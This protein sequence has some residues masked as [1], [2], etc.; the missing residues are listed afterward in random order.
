MSNKQKNLTNKSKTQHKMSKIHGL[1]Q[2]TQFSNDF[3]ITTKLNTTLSKSNLDYTND[4]SPLKHDISDA[5]SN[6]LNSG[7]LNPKFERSHSQKMHGEENQYL[8]NVDN[9][10]KMFYSS[11]A[12]RKNSFYNENQ[13]SKSLERKFKVDYR[14]NEIKI[15]IGYPQ[16]KLGESFATT[17]K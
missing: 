16:D 2:S 7:L 6:S 15:L 10:L 5:L 13:S 8:Q 12:S 17:Q 14:R 3:T 11:Q 9:I 4:L 1:K